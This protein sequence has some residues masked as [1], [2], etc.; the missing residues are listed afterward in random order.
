MFNHVATVPWPRPQPQI[1]WID[2]YT[3]IGLWLDTTVG[4]EN[5]LWDLDEHHPELCTVSFTQAKYKTLFL[6]K[7]TE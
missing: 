7:W 4:R 2:R 3:C 5:W 1:D 6:L